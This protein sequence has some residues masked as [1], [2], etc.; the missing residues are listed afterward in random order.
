MSAAST[1][2]RVRYAVVGLGHIAQVAVLPAFRSA[3]NSQL[4]TVVSSDAHKRAKVTQQYRLAESYSYDEYEQAL[5]SVDAVYI[6]LPNHLH[7]EYTVGAAQAGKHVLCEKPMAVTESDCEAMI[8]AVRDNGVKLMIAYRLHFEAGNLEAVRIA[9]NETIGEARF[10]SSEFAQQVAEDNVR[11]TEPIEKGGGPVYDM[12]VYCINAAR[13]LFHAEPTRVLAASAT[14]R[15][16]A[17]FDKTNEMASATLQFP[18]D[19][20]ATFTCSFGAADISRYTLAGTKGILTADPAYEYSTGVKHQ[21]MIDGMTKKRSF[22][23][24]DQFAAELAYFSD[25]I[26]RNKEPEPSGA[27]GLADV[28]IVRAIYE[29]ARRGTAVELT[30]MPEKKKPSAHQEIYRPAHGKPETH[31]VKSASGE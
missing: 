28:K 27:E 1:K 16:D 15:G 26:M 29:S 11:I 20:L 2:A 14:T 23:K 18:E 24:R 31:K 8:E 6:A 7:R 13:Y 17:R 3:G 12:G 10:F 22:P 30:G 5:E 21:L 9:R 19:R 4:V 25:C